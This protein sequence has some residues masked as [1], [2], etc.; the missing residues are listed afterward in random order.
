MAYGYLTGKKK[1][2]FICLDKNTNNNE[3][4]QTF[5]RDKHE[6]RDKEVTGKMERR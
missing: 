1:C 6:L 4:M 3:K 2:W 5:E